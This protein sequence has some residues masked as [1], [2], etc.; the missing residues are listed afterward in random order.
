MTELS[1]TAEERVQ[2]H[3]LLAGLSSPTRPH[4]TPAADVFD[5][6][7]IST[8]SL[9]STKV[10]GEM[11]ESLEQQVEQVSCLLEQNLLPPSLVPQASRLQVR[12]NLTLLI[13]S[14]DVNTEV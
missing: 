3:P 6:V 8:F 7:N 12:T 4:F 1:G 2:V 13:H 14:V 11:Q 9:V 10:V 5:A